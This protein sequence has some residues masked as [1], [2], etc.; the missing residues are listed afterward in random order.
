MLQSW[1]QGQA[2]HITQVRQSDSSHKF[3]PLMIFQTNKTI[4]NLCSPDDYNRNIHVQFS[5]DKLYYY[6]DKLNENI[7]TNFFPRHLCSDKIPCFFG[8]TTKPLGNITFV[9]LNKCMAYDQLAK[10]TCLKTSMA[11][12]LYCIESNKVAILR[13]E[14]NNLWQTVGKLD[15]GERG[16]WQIQYYTKG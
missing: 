9:R 4:H 13:K 5:P 12:V 14:A 8:T 15:R 6:T 1:V 16:P 11:S 10:I 3:I 7:S 2:Q